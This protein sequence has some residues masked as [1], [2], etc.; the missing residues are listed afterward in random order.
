VEHGN[1]DER[2]NR[3]AQRRAEQRERE[4]GALAGE[5]AAPGEATRAAFHVGK[6]HA[7]V[8]HAAEPVIRG[9]AE[10]PTA[11]GDDRI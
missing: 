4:R 6:A 9:H 3:T 5:A 8:G 11:S 10:R 1:A 2:W 7:K